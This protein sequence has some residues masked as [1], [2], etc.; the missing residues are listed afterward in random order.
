MNWTHTAGLATCLM[1][2]AGPVAAQALKALVNP[3][4][5]AEQNRFAV[6]TK[7]KQALEQAMV[8]AKAPVPAVTL[9]TDAAADLATTRSKI[10]DVY[11]APAHV[12]GSAVRYGYQPLWTLE[13]PVQAVLVA[14]TASPI[15]NLQQAQGKALGLPSQDSVVTYL[16]RGELNAANTTTKRHFGALYQTRYQ[17]AL[18]PCLQLKRCDVVAVERAVFDRWVAA[19]EPVKTVMQTRAVPGLSVV[20][21]EG[22]KPAPEALAATLAEAWQAVGAAKPSPVALADFDYVSTLGY[23]TPRALPGAQVPDAATVAKLMQAGAMYVDTR[24][25]VEFKAGRPNGAVWVPYVEKSAKDPDFKASEDQFDVSK[26]PANKQT[27]VV[28]ACNGAECWKSYKASLAA[29]Q[30]GYSQVHWF[31]GGFPEWRAAGLPVASG[32]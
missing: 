13:P 32:N 2:L 1:A 24:T 27:P 29:I 12:V 16:L 4:D 3:G 14:L 30:A 26:L 15:G 11:V 19:G 28:L 5:Q 31:R 9:S 17:D 8:K 20:V 21:R 6:F 23:F 10:F 22:S 18:L 25:D 7:H